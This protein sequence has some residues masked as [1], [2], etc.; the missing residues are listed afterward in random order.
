MRLAKRSFLAC[1]L[2]SVPSRGIRWLVLYLCP[3]FRF[4]GPE[5]RTSF[6]FAKEETEEDHVCAIPGQRLQDSDREPN[7]MMDEWPRRW[8]RIHCFSKEHL[9]YTSCVPNEVQGTVRVLR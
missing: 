6:T 9:A 7:D 4:K 5:Y 2:I 8:P 1:K 3:K